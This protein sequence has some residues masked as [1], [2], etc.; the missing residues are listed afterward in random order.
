MLCLGRYL[1]QLAPKHFS[2][3]HFYSVVLV[4]LQ[5]WPAGSLKVV[6]TSRDNRLA[7]R[8]DE[9]AVFGRHRRCVMLPFNNSKV[10]VPAPTRVLTQLTLLSPPLC[11]WHS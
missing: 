6:V 2:H 3:L 10:R 11:R 5:P 4:T 7:G 8:A 1:P 9:D